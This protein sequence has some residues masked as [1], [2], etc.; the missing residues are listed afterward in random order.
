M[1]AKSIS[2]VWNFAS[3]SQSINILRL[4]SGFKPLPYGLFFRAKEK[5]LG[6]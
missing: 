1:V 2:C 4:I 6:F 5:D 3:L